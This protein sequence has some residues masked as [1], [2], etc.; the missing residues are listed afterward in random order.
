MLEAFGA[1]GV[2]LGYLL[3]S[4]AAMGAVAIL[5]GVLCGPL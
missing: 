4:A 3:L 1:A 5:I 2:F